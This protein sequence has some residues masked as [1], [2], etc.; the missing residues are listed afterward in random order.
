[1]QTARTQ[2]LG[3]LLLAPIFLLATL[4]ATAQYSNQQQD[5]RNNQT[6]YS[7]QRGD[8]RVSQ[9]YYSGMREGGRGGNYDRTPQS[10]Y[11]AGYDDR[12]HQPGGIGPGKGA[13]I[14]AAGYGSDTGACGSADD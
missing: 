7:N 11:R 4:P 3:P 14:G 9:N 13:A 1:L 2:K 5:N 12:Y 6:S 10:N 8:N